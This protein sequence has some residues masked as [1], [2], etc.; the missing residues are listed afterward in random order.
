MRST[1]DAFMLAPI[2]VLAF[3]LLSGAT[4]SAFEVRGISFSDFH[5]SGNSCY[6]CGGS[7]GGSSTAAPAAPD[8]REVERQ[9][10]IVQMN[11]QW[12][13]GNRRGAI[14]L[15]LQALT[16]RDD[17]G[18]R[19][20]AREN[21]AQLVFEDAR[22]LLDKGDK[23]GALAGFRRAQAI[24]PDLFTPKGRQYIADLEQDVAREDKDE[25][26]NSAAAEQRREA[27]DLFTNDV[28]QGKWVEARNAFYSIPGSGPPY[29][30]AQNWSGLYTAEAN[31]ALD[32]GRL[33]E[34]IRSFQS[35]LIEQPDN[36]SAKAQLQAALAQRNKEAAPIQALFDK[37]TIGSSPVDARGPKPL[38]DVIAAIPE[39]AQSP[40]AERARK[41][42]Q[43]AAD[44]DWV[45]ARAWYQDALNHDPGNKVLE[46]AVDLADW[47]V[48]HRNPDQVKSRTPPASP[49]LRSDDARRMS[50]IYMQLA[51]QIVH[52]KQNNDRDRAKADYF[53]HE[54][55]MQAVE[56]EQFDQAVKSARQNQRLPF[57]QQ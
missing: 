37:G 5:K 57:K 17:P 6:Q 20:W 53:A 54:L 22:A 41:G 34:A 40:A 19:E 16:L 49:N 10:L 2:G 23:R 30:S 51:D 42:L 3:L 11:Y 32:G 38:A 31:I 4:A 52:S 9:N 50:V 7:A 25:A 46:R 43:A 12:A 55:E 33:D 45:V 44:H 21:N 28:Q 8:P 29:I 36:A 48:Q 13:S 39:L 14:D 15:A 56:A 47:M 27:I 24:W 1:L 35:A 18:L 26:I